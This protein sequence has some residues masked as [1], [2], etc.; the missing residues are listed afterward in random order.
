MRLI[1]YLKED[2]FD[3]MELKEFK[4]KIHAECKPFLNASKGYSLY[5]GMYKKPALGKLKVR[6]D[7]KPLDTP[8]D[9]HKE[10][11]KIFTK[12]FGWP[13]RSSGLLTTGDKTVAGSYGNAYQVFPIGKFRFLWSSNVHD[14][15]GRYVEFMTHKGL[16]YA[17]GGDWEYFKDSK[18][19]IVTPGSM[20]LS[21]KEL[22]VHQKDVFKQL[23]D[24]IKK[25]Y[26]DKK[27]D[28]AI[29]SRNE[30]MIDCKE[31]YAIQE[32]YIN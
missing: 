16:S 21:K 27:L 23:N 29:L 7:R 31:Y 30:I 15:Y 13:A 28:R 32:V 6:K 2:I 17:G 22:A 4:K 26:S 14:L 18:Q 12:I 1:H 25:E 10:F 11:D 3:V 5:R 20:Y 24:L 19:R 8:L 9:V